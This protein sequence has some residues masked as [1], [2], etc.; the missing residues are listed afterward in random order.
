[1]ADQKIEDLPIVKS[2]LEH[3]LPAPTEQQKQVVS[4]IIFGILYSKPEK[5]VMFTFVYGIV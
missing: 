4:Q 1:M 2:L 3:D 5:A